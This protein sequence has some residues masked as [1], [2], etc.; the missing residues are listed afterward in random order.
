MR[1]HQTHTHM[2]V[3]THMRTH[4]HK[5]MHPP[6]Y[7]V[8]QQV[9]QHGHRLLHHVQAVRGEA[10]AHVGCCGDCHTLHP[11]GE[12]VQVGQHLHAQE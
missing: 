10:T 4:T 9:C 11:C 12:E 3:C 1:T 6:T 5:H 2:H 7:L 8:L